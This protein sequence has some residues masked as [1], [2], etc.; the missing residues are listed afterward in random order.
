MLVNVI[1]KDEKYCKT[2]INGDFLIKIIICRNN[3]IKNLNYLLS[4]FGRKLCCVFIFFLVIVSNNMEWLTNFC[5][6]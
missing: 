3:P 2:I 4:H 5:C 1:F 6:G